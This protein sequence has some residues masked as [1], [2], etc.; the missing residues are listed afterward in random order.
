MKPIVETAPKMQDNAKLPALLRT[1]QIRKAASPD[2]I[3][4]KTILKLS[5]NRFET[6]IK[7]SILPRKNFRPNLSIWKIVHKLAGSGAMA[8]INALINT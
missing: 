5:V 4:L 6:Y 7:D 1:P 8:T 2:P 3:M